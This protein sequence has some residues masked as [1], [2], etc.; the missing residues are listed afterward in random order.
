[1]NIS[2]D[3]Y[4]IFY[5]VAICE[6]ITKASEKLFISQPAISQTIAKLEEE[7]GVTLFL[8]TKKGVKLTNIGEKI[9]NVV[10][11]GLNDLENVQKIALEQE[12]L[13]SGEL[14]ISCGSNIAKRL[15]LKSINDFSI[16]HPSIP[17]YLEN[18]PLDKSLEKLKNGKLDIVIGQNNYEETPFTFQHLSFEKYVFVSKIGVGFEKVILMNQGTYSRKLFDK[19]ISQ[20][21]NENVKHIIE[22]SGYNIAIELCKLGLGVILIPYYMVEELL[23]NNILTIMN[24][25]SFDEMQE[26]GYYFNQNNLTKTAQEFL[27]ILE[28]NKP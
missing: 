7:L 12:Q 15:L 9:F 20:I 13:L 6:N 27:K 22:V 26:F 25:D 8:R 10:K 17:I 11:S 23:K 3:Y 21:G 4:K 14:F 24:V 2:L 19:Y 18:Y 28:Q 5:Q 16:Q 1:M